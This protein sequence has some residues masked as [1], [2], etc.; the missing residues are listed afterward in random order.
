MMRTNYPKVLQWAKR[1][2]D[3][4]GGNAALRGQWMRN[5][6]IPST[7]LPLLRIFFNEMFPVLKSTCQVLTE[8][9][10]EERP[11]KLPCGSFGPGS[12]DQEVPNGPLTCEFQLPVDEESVVKERRMVIPYQVWLLQRLEETVMKMIERGA[13]EKYRGFLSSIDGLGLL[14]LTKMLSGCRVKKIKGELFVDY[15]AISKRT[16]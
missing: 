16:K 11:S 5:D 10:K 1:L 3:D 15:D 6:S 13:R 14:D 4:G 2:H 7:V 9:I 8:Y 12:I